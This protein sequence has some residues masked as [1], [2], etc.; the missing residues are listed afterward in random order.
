MQSTLLAAPGKKV[1]V[2]RVRPSILV[3]DDDPSVCRI[4]Q[5][6]V[7]P[8]NYEVQFSETIAGAIRVIGQ[9]AFDLYLLDYKLPDG[10]GLDIAEAIR[11]KGLQTVRKALGLSDSSNS[12]NDLSAGEIRSPIKTAPQ[13]ILSTKKRHLKSALIVGSILV[14]CIFSIGIYLLIN[15]H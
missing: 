10:S 2:G 14:L 11:A 5:R 1:T 4:I 3:V 7:S 9:R 6:M 15:A 13:I 8:A 12:A